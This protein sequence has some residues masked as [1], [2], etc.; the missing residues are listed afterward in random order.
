MASAGRQFKCSVDSCQE[1][2]HALL[3]LGQ[4]VSTPVT[5]AFPQQRQ[6]C[7]WTGF[8]RGP[9]APAAAPRAARGD[10]RVA[11]LGNTPPH[12]CAVFPTPPQGLGRRGAGCRLL[13]ATP[14]GKGTA[15]LTGHVRR[16]PG[17]VATLALQQP[18]ACHCQLYYMARVQ[19]VPPGCP[20]T[21]WDPGRKGGTGLP[22]EVGPQECV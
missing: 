19:P 16:T 2:P 18:L 3:L 14:G 11:S 7:P 12:V 1:T 5:R 9:G 10:P 13:A 21:D 6:A 8:R 22:G 4:S 17:L 20:V 15:S